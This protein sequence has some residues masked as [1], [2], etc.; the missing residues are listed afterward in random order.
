MNAAEAEMPQFL[1]PNTSQSSNTPDPTLPMMQL[2]V[3]FCQTL[4]PGKLPTIR[5]LN[6]TSEIGG[7]PLYI[8]P[9]LALITITCN[10]ACAHC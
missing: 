9:Q 10:Q 2:N 5:K 1:V 4:Q 8:L 3:V 7:V 6:L